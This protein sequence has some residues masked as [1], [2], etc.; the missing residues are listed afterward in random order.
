METTK[1]IGNFFYFFIIYV[2]LS[3]T[4]LAFFSFFSVEE[5]YMLLL[6]H[7]DLIMVFSALLVAWTSLRCYNAVTI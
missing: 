5:R 3:A 4:K 6:L 2:T 1:F 7:C